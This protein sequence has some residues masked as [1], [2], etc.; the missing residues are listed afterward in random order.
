MN[1][2]AFASDKINPT[3]KINFALGRVEKNIVGK[4]ENAGYKLHFSQNFQIFFLSCFFFVNGEFRRDKGSKTVYR[5]KTHENAS[6][7]RE[8]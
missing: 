4:A 3:Q 8:I 2:K 5:L 6:L 7:H 1:W